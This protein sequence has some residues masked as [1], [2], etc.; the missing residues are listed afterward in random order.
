MTSNC[1]VEPKKS[2]IDRVFTRHS[3]G[4]PGVKHIENYDYSKVIEMAKNMK[5]FEKDETEKLLNVGYGKD[6]VLGIA[7]TVINA[8]KAQ[9]VKHFFFIGGCDG[10]EG[11]RNYF[12]ELA[13]ATPKDSL[14]LTGTFFPSFLSHRNSWLWKVQ[15]Q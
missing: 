10:S 1:L 15:V 9:Q 2:Y 12:K 4:W 7:D 3:V 8:I 6:T 13:L 5:G 11:E 14:I